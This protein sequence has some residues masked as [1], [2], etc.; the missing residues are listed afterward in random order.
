MGKK[1]GP[2]TVGENMNVLEWISSDYLECRIMR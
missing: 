1:G 2:N